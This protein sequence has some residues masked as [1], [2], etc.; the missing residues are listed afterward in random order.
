V[1]DEHR[2]RGHRVRLEWGRHGAELLSADCAVVVVV[3]V[4]SFCTSVDIAV[5]RGAAVLP[6]VTGDAA[7]ALAEAARTGAQPA[8]PRDGAGPSLR[9]SS[10]TGLAPGTT[11]ALPSPNGATL[12]RAAASGGAAVI[13]GCL[14]NAAAV[15][16]AVAA[17]D[18]PIG[19]VPAGERWPDGSLRPALEDVLGA[20]AIAAHLAGRSPEA[21]SAARQF[22]AV[23]L[24]SRDLLGVLAGCSSGRELIADGYGAD[25]ELAAAL[26]ASPE[27]PRLRGGV[28]ARTVPA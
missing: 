7:T 1:R 18:G 5:G 24:T 16:A 10:L 28:L 20:G 26:D 17:V 15:A 4:L 6:Q 2:Q 23:A 27:V 13:A 3:D 14:R 11:L 8:G 21:E 12:C 22:G 25:V 9:P 19:L